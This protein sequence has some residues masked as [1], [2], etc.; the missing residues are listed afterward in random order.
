MTRAYRW[1]RRAVLAAALATATSSAARADDKLLRV[2]FVP[3]EKLMAQFDT[4][5]TADAKVGAQEINTSEHQTF[6]VSLE[7]HETS[8]DGGAVVGQRFERMRVKTT[9]AGGE[10]VD[11]DSAAKNGAAGRT[12]DM[13]ATFLA[14]QS[15][16]L[17]IHCDAR[18]RVTR[19]NANQVLSELVRKEPKLAARLGGVLTDEGVR[20]MTGL[21]G[22]A[23]PDGAVGVGDTWTTSH[24]RTLPLL[25]KQ[26]VKTEYTYLGPA[27]FKGQ[28]R[29]KIGVAMQVDFRLP[30]NLPLKM[31]VVKQ[32]AQGAIWLDDA[33]G[34][35]TDTEMTQDLTLSVTTGEQKFQQHVVV[36]QYTSVRAAADTSRKT[37]GR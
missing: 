19:T 12:G 8:P 33:A 11:F 13:L 2:R 5:V 9:G 35:V 27:K 23:L 1:L 7:T 18:G 17:R 15:A 34:R 37:A 16:D 6:E 30:Q 36:S 10:M 25:G 31:E 14:I 4:D 3:G 24:D 32:Q 21:G 20:N 28:P 26:T 29:E 22:V